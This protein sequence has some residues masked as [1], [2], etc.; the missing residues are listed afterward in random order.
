MSR[1]RPT[2]LHVLPLEDR[3]VPAAMIVDPSFGTKGFL[4]LPDGAVASYSKAV[5][6]PDGGVLFVGVGNGA[7]PA[8]P[9]ILLLKLTAA[10]AVD[11]AFG[12]AGR[13]SL[14][15]GLKNIDGTPSNDSFSDVVV[16]ADGRIEVLG[17]ASYTVRVTTGGNNFPSSVNPLIGYRLTAAGALDPSYDGDGRLPIGPPPSDDSNQSQ[18]PSTRLLPDGSFVGV[19][20]SSVYAPSPISL[21]NPQTP[22]VQDLYLEAF[23]VTA[24]G[25]FDPSFD[26]DGKVKIAL[27]SSRNFGNSSVSVGTVFV[28]TGNALVFGLNV[29]TTTSA[30]DQQQYS[31]SVQSSVAQLNAAGA[32]DGGFGTNGRLVLQDVAASQFGSGDSVAAVVGIQPGGGVLTQL[33]FGFGGSSTGLFR[34]TAAGKVDPGFGFGGTLP[35]SGFGFG[36]IEVKG[37]GSFTSNGTKYTADG[38]PIPRDATTLADLLERSPLLPT[39]ANGSQLTTSTGTVYLIGGSPKGPLPGLP[40][41]TFIGRLIVDPNPPGTGGGTGGGTGPAGP[42][43]PKGATGL[44]GPAG[45]QGP[46]GTGTGSGLLAPRAVSTGGGGVALVRA[47]GTEAAVNPFA[48]YTGKVRTASA[49]GAVFA[50]TGPGVPSQVV[51]LDA[52]TGKTVRTF[53]TF[54]PTFLAGVNVAAADVNGD[55]VADVVMTPE[56]GGG[57]RVRI[58][59]GATGATIVDFFGIE[60]SSFRGGARAVFGDVN[61]DGTPDLTVVAADGG[62]P[63]VAIYDGKSLLAGKPAPLAGDFFAF[64]SGLRAGLTVSAG[65]FN[66]D[67]F[68]DLA[69]T[70]NVGAGPVVAVFSGKELTANR[71]TQ[72]ALFVQGDGASLTGAT[73]SSRDIDGDGKADLLVAAGGRVRGYLGRN[74]VPGTP[75]AAFDLDPAAAAAAGIVVG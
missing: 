58:V 57:P 11:P 51:M 22:G 21:L 36:E 34:V 13:V 9:N 71:P 64:D 59:N 10:G 44:Q 14:D 39:G 46:A 45:P 38:Q 41:Q 3:A 7:T 74:L 55:G 67:G 49:N 30:S 27:G 65:D 69:I 16:L 47:D 35:S 4:T 70:P 73:S 40:G 66:N 52:A 42:A 29:T 28:R 60:D 54:E 26:G 12:T 31:Q 63:R 53:D 32:L 50:A 2:R 6:T 56:G 24:G 15:S 17:N 68:A 33:L 75:V 72:L 20:G 48:G 37:D 61:G 18:S 19:Y 25:T 1:R 62:G 23:R 43:G 8:D 5:A